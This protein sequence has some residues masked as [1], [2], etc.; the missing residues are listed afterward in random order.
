[1]GEPTYSCKECGKKSE[2]ELANQRKF[3]KQSY[4]QAWIRR[5]YCASV[6]S[7]SQPIDNI[8]TKWVRQEAVDV[9]IAATRKPGRVNHSVKNIEWL[10]FKF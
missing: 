5:V 9:A 1:M 3:I 6:V 4:F 7:N 8:A 2:G 10:V